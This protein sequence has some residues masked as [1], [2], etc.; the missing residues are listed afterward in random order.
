M[1][2]GKPEVSHITVLVALVLLQISHI[3]RNYI[4]GHHAIVI[5]D[6]SQITMLDVL[7]VLHFTMLAMLERLRIPC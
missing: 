3:R 2:V 1:T 6:L 5:L 7:D 4:L